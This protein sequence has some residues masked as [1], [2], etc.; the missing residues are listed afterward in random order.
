[1]ETPNTMRSVLWSKV[2]DETD[3]LT[4][5]EL[6]TF[7]CKL[8]T[9][10]FIAGAMTDTNLPA[11]IMM[12]KHY[13]IPNTLVMLFCV[14]QAPRI[15]GY[16]R[17]TWEASA[18]EPTGDSIEGIPTVELLDHL[19]TSKSL[20]LD[21][22][23]EKFHTKRHRIETL[24]KKLR[25]LEVLVPGPNNA[26]VLNSQMSRQDVASI[27]KGKSSAKDLEPLFRKDALGYTSR[28]SMPEIEERATPPPRAP[29]FNLKVLSHVS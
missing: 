18:P 5:G 27:F 22:A 4:L 25:E 26:S 8:G 10:L 7:L 9:A 14:F 19:F 16:V 6:I 20:K 2:I 3:Q 15:W 17:E 12:W 1:M 24:I 21:A 23:T 28:P 13:L 11:R 29:G